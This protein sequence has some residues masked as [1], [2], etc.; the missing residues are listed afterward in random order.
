MY[1]NRP[2]VVFFY[3]Y[4]TLDLNE[5]IKCIVQNYSSSEL[6]LFSSPAHDSAYKC[7][8]FLFHKYIESNLKINLNV[9]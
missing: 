9:A 8:R 2:W 3:T 6:K 4:S 1:M 5:E 7:N